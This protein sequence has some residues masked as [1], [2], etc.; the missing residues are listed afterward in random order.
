MFSF[1]TCLTI[2]SLSAF[3]IALL[4]VGV[5]VYRFRWRLRF[6]L[7][8]LQH[9][10]TRERHSGP[11]PVPKYDAFV[12]YDSDDNDWVLRVLRPELEDCRGLR[13]CLHE[14]DFTPGRFISDNIIEHMGESGAILPVL[15]NAFLHSDW[16]RF[17]LFVA[18]KSGLAHAQRRVPVVPVLLEELDRTSMDSLV[19]A[20][21]NTTTY[22]AWPREDGVLVAAY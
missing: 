9:R 1:I 20:L 14:R 18:V 8:T 17:E 21:L 22:L 3:T 6:F 16:C 4:V 15:S 12:S 13:L 2:V 11:E 7:Y 5:L 19:Y 10:L